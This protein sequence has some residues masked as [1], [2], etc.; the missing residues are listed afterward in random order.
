MNE[1]KLQSSYSSVTVLREYIFSKIF[2]SKMFV[3]QTSDIRWR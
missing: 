3:D 2:T 1:P